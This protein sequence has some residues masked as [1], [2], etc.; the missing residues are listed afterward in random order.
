MARDSDGT[1]PIFTSLLGCTD[2]GSVLI[3]EGIAEYP[4]NFVLS[5]VQREVASQLQYEMD[6]FQATMKIVEEKI[7]EVELSYQKTHSQTVQCLHD[8]VSPSCMVSIRGLLFCV[9]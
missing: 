1:F 2:T 8:V 3:N 4:T 6:G 5:T 9:Q 7:E